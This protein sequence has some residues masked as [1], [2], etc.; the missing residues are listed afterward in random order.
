MTVLRQALTA[1]FQLLNSNDQIRI[2]HSLATL[3]GKLPQHLL[4]SKFGAIFGASRRSAH[5]TSRAANLSESINKSCVATIKGD[6][7]VIMA[8]RSPLS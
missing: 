8:D 2:L 4:K 1:I 5:C 3:V 6:D 7:G